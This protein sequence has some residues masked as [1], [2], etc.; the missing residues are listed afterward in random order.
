M[1]AAA[2]PLMADAVDEAAES[3]PLHVTPPAAPQRPLW[4]LVRAAAGA[5]LS[6]ARATLLLLF[7]T[8]FFLAFAS[9]EHRALLGSAV[10]CAVLNKIFDLAPPLVRRL[11]RAIRR[12]AAHPPASVGSWPRGLS[13]KRRAA[14]RG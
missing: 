10:L 6:I 13:T 14:A 4:R 11:L 5:L 3:A 9:A 2:K 7:I 12:H 1:S 8:L